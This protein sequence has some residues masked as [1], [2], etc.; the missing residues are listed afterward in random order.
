MVRSQQPPLLVAALPSKRAE[1]ILFARPIFAIIL[2]AWA[3]VGLAKGPAAAGGKTEIVKY[4]VPGSEDAVG[5][6]KS[7]AERRV[8]DDFYRS[9]VLAQEYQAATTND[10]SIFASLMDDRIVNN[11]ERFGRG[12][13]LTKSAWV[14][15]FSSGSHHHSTLHHD[16]VCLVAF[17]DNTVVATGRSTSVLHYGG[18]L[19]PGPRLLTEVWVK[20][21]GRWQMIVHAM[22]DLQDGMEDR[23]AR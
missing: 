21:A 10:A 6:V 5:L 19:S 17:G 11:D 2:L 23:A 3:A 18:K 20:I 13:I 1:R 12:V 16:H 14:G 15:N 4:P 22:S 7:A 9:K 8:L